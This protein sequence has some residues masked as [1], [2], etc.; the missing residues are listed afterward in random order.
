MIE[1]NINQLILAV[2]D[3]PN[4]LKA[5]QYILTKAGYSVL[6]ARDGDEALPKVSDFIAQNWH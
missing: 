2:D 3:A 6:T 5:V 4:I 1:K